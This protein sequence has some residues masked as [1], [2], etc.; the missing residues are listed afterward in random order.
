MPPRITTALVVAASVISLAPA[1]PASASPLSTAKPNLR[2]CFDG[3]CKLTITKRV[4]FRVSSRFGITRLS[5]G[6]TADRVSVKG[7]G[8]GVATAG[9][10]TKGGSATVSGI[11]FR[12]VS[13]SS[14]KAVLRLTPV[15]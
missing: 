13:L 12:L 2:A 5:V 8:P 9:S 11:H 15:R 14:R 3:S 6:F 4:S 1:V 7:A 10:F